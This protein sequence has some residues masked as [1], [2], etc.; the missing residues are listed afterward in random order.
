MNGETTTERRYFVLSL[1]ND[2][3][4]FG[5][6]VRAHWGIENLV[7]WVLD[8][9]FREDMSRIRMHHG[10]ENVAVV[11]HIALNLLWQ[12]ATFQGSLKTNRL[13]AGRNNQYLAKALCGAKI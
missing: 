11:R 8:V 10:S 13:K 12:E 4:R 9:A 2:A 1:P 5:T 6:S 3:Q 7:H